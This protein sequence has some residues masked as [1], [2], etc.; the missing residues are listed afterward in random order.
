MEKNI[1]Q[2]AIINILD[3][4]NVLMNHYDSHFW[5]FQIFG[6]RSLDVGVHSRLQSFE[7]WNLVVVTSRSRASVRMSTVAEGAKGLV[8]R[9]STFLRIGFGPVSQKDRAKSW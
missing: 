7:H 1:F 5:Q 9:H 8:C 6:I 2:K 3:M 4:L